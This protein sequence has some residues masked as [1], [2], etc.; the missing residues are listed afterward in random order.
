MSDHWIVLHVEKKTQKRYVCSTA[1]FDPLAT[2]RLVPKNIADE[3]KTKYEERFPNEDYEL[4]Q[5]ILYGD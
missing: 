3:L 2:P 4:A 5:V 1:M